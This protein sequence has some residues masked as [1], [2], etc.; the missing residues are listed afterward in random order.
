[1]QKILWSGIMVV[2]FAL[3]QTLTAQTL[4]SLA[5]TPS[6]SYDATVATEWFKL[7]LELVQETK[8][9]SPP[10]ASRT[11]A[12]MAVTLYES[13]APFSE[14]YQ[15]LVGQLEALWWYSFSLSD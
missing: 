6:L 3:A 15:S 8:G 11:F 7:S 5:G 2:L 13:V 14:D 10:V 1:M 4:I 9:Y 12:Y